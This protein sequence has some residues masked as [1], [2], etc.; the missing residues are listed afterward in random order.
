MKHET[1]TLHTSGSVNLFI[2]TWKPDADAKGT[3]V[4]VH[5][6]HEHSGRYHH[7]AEYFVRHNFNVYALDQRGHGRSRGDTLG[8]F[9]RF[10]TLSE[11]LR[12]F[13]EQVRSEAKVGPLFLLGHSMGGL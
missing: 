9:E 12:R 1:D 10:D 13:I 8:Y 2:Q 7:V 11:D 3:L 6:L 5:G 4:I